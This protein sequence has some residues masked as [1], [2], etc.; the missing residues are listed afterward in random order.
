MS[1]PVPDSVLDFIKRYEKF[2]VFGHVEPDGDCVASQ[3][4]LAS[5]LSRCGKQALLF[6]E[7][8]FDRPEIFSFKHR[9]RER[10]GEGD[11]TDNPGAVILDC[12]TVERIGRMGQTIAGLP[13]LVIDHHSSGEHYGEVRWVT[14]RAPSVSFMIQRLIEEFPDEP[15]GQEAELILFGLARDTGYFRHLDENSRD[16]F[17]AVARLVTAGASPR[18]AYRM[19]HYGWELGKVKLLA[20][21]L[22][23]SERVL[24]GDA[25]ITYQNL[26]DLRFAGSPASRGSDEVYRILLAVKGVEVVALLQEEENGRCSVGLRSNSYCNVGA[27][28]RSMGGGGHDQAAGYTAT[29][30]IAATRKQLVAALAKVLKG[31]SNSD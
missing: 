4:V 11:L 27:L 25:L 7:G 16:V 6:S 12:S 23:R 14:A 2:L 9:F 5:F 30:S 10:V 22:Q 26:E 13:T 17:E 20:A 21:A 19:C 3:L 15:T 8:P 28:A 31:R 1:L 24:G 18:M 29:G